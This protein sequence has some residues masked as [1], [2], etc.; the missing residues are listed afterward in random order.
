MKSWAHG[1]TVVLKDMCKI[2]VK[3]GETLSSEPGWRPPAV[4]ESME[5]LIPWHACFPVGVS[6]LEKAW[7]PMGNRLSVA[8]SE[9]QKEVGDGHLL[10][11]KQCTES[12]FYCLFIINM[13][14]PANR[15]PC[16]FST[17]TS[18]PGDGKDD[19][20][21]S[22]NTKVLATRGERPVYAIAFVG[23]LSDIVPPGI[24]RICAA[25]TM[26]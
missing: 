16:S 14:T 4:R 10:M 2:R 22:R 1:Q 3:E 23:A 21:G 20:A 12:H 8:K 24:V 13:H 15:W 5:L 17:F 26:I 9:G 25:R 11:Q 7:N 18:K 6:L 19:R